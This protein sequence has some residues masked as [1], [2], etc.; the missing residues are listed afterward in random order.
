ME[1]ILVLRFAIWRLAASDSERGVDSD[2][3]Q[4]VASVCQGLREHL[5]NGCASLD[6]YAVA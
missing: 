5:R 3:L 1:G 2:I 4:L 6:I